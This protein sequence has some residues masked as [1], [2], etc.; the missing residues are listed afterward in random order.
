MLNNKKC[1]IWGAK[2]GGIA[3]AN[4][5]ERMFSANI[6][7]FIDNDLE[8]S[9]RTILGKKIYSFVD[10]KDKFDA[11]EEVLV[12]A[13]SQFLSEIKEMAVA[14]GIDPVNI[15]DAYSFLGPSYE[16]DVVNSCNLKCP[17][18]PQANYPNA[19]NPAL[20]TVDRFK[21]YVD[22][23]LSDTPNVYYIDLFCWSEPFLNTK[24]AEFV[25]ICKERKIACFLSS[26]FSHE[27]NLKDVVKQHP[28][29]LRI[30]ISGYTQKIYGIDHVGG[31][32][33]LVKSNM[34][35]LR[36]YIDRYSPETY[37]EVAYHLY[38]YNKCDVD[39]VKILC[40]ELN[41]KFAPFTVTLLPVERLVDYKEGV[42]KEL[43]N[44]TI[45]RL[46]YDLN[47]AL[48]RL[49]PVDFEMCCVA[50]DMVTV[51]ADGKVL[52]CD[53]CFDKTRSVVSEDFL[54]VRFTDIVGRKRS[55]EVCLKC[56][57][58]GIPIVVNAITD[59]Q[60]KMR[61]RLEAD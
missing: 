24:L 11:K 50:K 60:G 36:S 21:T 1:W 41:F 39:N 17:T 61:E 47:G 44:D 20:M 32:I 56:R 35:R 49:T 28:D 4:V 15:V 12:L 33:N 31:D 8:F 46:A 54:S 30:S 40:S 9:S 6:V 27:A 45:S 51:L 37:V 23:I 5:V 52:V 59:L 38:N 58:Y 26:N 2:T 55:N 48:N 14:G 7:G 29:Y 25:R 42:I 19:L 3:T 43:P 34:Y 18:C 16:I 10:F 13:P 53:Y 22:K 57:K